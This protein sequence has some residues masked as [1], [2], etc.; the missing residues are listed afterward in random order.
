MREVA[1][2]FKD[3]PSGAAQREFFLIK[4]SAPNGSNAIIYFSEQDKTYNLERLGR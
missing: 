2:L 1:C 3:T 4:G